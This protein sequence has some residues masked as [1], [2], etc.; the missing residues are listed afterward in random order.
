MLRPFDPIEQLPDIVEVQ[1]RLSGA[2]IADVDDERRPFLRS[3]RG[4]QSTA[5]GVVD[6]VLEGSPAPPGL[7]P[8]LRGDVLVER[9]R[10]THIKILCI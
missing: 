5:Q 1:P 6:N 4:G 9:Q 3:G 10:R 8:E 2:Q 7:R